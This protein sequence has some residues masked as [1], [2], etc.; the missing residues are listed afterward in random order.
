MGGRTPC[1]HSFDPATKVVMADGDT[2]PIGDVKLGDK[3]LSTDPATG[4]TEGKTV[5]VLHHNDDRD[6]ADVTVKDA[7][8][9]KSSVLHT[10][11]HH[12]V[13]NSGK[14]EWT[15]AKDLK[16]GDKLRSPDGE[17]TQTV[18]A[19]KVWTGLKWMD[20]LTVNDV[21]TYYVLAG[22]IPVLVHNCNVRLTKDEA[23]SL[24]PP[25][26]GL[27]SILSKFREKVTGGERQQLEGEACH[28]CGK[29]SD[30]YVG[31]HQPISA[32]SPW[33]AIQRLFNQCRKCS[34]DQGSATSK[35]LAILRNHFG[36]TDPQAVPDANAKLMSVLDE[37][38]H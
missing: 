10:T 4:K 26:A 17:T 35:G 27:K 38:V 34:N 6:L 31:D 25:K 19:V 3:V 1:T 7:K 33:G 28:S 18:T 22:A 20:D 36:I 14:D 12:P 8:T 24:Q 37:H 9:G 30:D 23:R 21:H 16:A 5:S 29:V 15:E 13:W 32:F 11:S 2:K